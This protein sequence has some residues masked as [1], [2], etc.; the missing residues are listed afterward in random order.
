MSEPPPGWVEVSFVGGSLDGQSRLLREKVPDI[1]EVI[2][3][4]EVYQY[5]AGRCVLVDDGGAD[6]ED[7]MGEVDGGER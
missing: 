7:T 3:T 1:Y 5:V 6:T 4:G 2:V